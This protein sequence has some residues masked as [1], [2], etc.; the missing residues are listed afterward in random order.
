MFYQIPTNTNSPTTIIIIV[1]IAKSC[2]K[3]SDAFWQW[4]EERGGQS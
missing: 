1:I 3:I 2:I 4:V